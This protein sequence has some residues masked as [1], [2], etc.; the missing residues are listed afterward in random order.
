MTKN[1]V[2]QEMLKELDWLVRFY[3]EMESE[4]DRQ[5]IELEFKHY[6]RAYNHLLANM[7]KKTPHI[8]PRKIEK[9]LEYRDLYEMQ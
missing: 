4:T 6:T 5:E 8:F 1:Q 7:Y 9:Y 3:Q 2:L